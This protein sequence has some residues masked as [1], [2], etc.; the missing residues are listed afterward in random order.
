MQKFLQSKKNRQMTWK[1][2]VSKSLEKGIFPNNFRKLLVNQL[3]GF[4]IRATLALNGLNIRQVFAITC[5]TSCYN[6][7]KYIPKKVCTF[8]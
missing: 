7:T 4:Y 3:T 5:S 6:R 2:P 8:A 1:F